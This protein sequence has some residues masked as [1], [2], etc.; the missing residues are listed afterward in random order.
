MGPTPNVYEPESGSDLFTRYAGTVLKTVWRAVPMAG[1]KTQHGFM[2]QKIL[3]YF[4]WTKPGLN[5]VR[6]VNKEHQLSIVI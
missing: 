5:L 3:Q 6:N 2:A 1:S 4:C